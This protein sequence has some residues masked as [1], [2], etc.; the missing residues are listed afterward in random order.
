[1]VRI[2]SVLALL[3]L[4]LLAAN[5]FVGLWIGDFN[6][7]ARNYREAFRHFEDVRRARGVSAG[8]LAAAK[9]AVAEAEAL[10]A[11]P[12]DR[13]T[14]HFYLGVG[15]SLLAMLVSSISVTY[16]IG[17]SRWCREVVET[18]QLSP[19]LALRSARIKRNAFPWAVASMLAIVV[20]AALGGLSDPSTPV[21]QQNPDW[22]AAFVT[23]HYAAAAFGL[24]FV[25]WSFWI[26]WNCIAK[27]YHVIDEIMA[28]VRRVRLA[29]G[30]PVEE[31]AS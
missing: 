29:R 1:M 12:R 16:F 18:Y 19:E 31:V 10:V 13:K 24:A 17:T 28:E 25:A 23:W 7:A 5:L 9:R 2:Y 26:Q 8:E 11:G 27:N 3:A 22:P 14:L 4:L 6:T 21:S 15:S 20:V 30:L